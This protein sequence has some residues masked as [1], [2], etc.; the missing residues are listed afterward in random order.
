HFLSGAKSAHFDE[1]ATPAGDGPDFS[2]RALLQIKQVNHKSLRWSERFHKML[3]KLS[4]RKT[5]V[6]REVIGRRGEVLNYRH[7]FFAQI[8]LAQFRTGLLRLDLV[9]ASVDR[10]ARDPVRQRHL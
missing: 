10:D 1:R 6:R 4:R 2:D 8:G 5:L 3:D 7:L 9:D